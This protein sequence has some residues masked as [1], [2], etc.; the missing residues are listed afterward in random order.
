MGREAHAESG[1]SGMGMEPQSTQTSQRQHSPWESGMRRP[2]RPA[3][4]RGLR[5]SRKSGAWQ[6]CI[7]CALRGEPL[8]RLRPYVRNCYPPLNRHTRAARLW[9]RFGE[10]AEEAL[11][12][13]MRR[14]QFER[15]FQQSHHSVLL[16]GHERFCRDVSCLGAD[17]RVLRC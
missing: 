11:G 17:P 6:R 5:G 10:L 9:A 8:P 7:L 1:G 15:E 12:S 4:Q 16:K 13:F 14:V 3:C 2:P